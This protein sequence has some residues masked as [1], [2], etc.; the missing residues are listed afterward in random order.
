M[1]AGT[2]SARIAA[3]TAAVANRYVTSTNMKVGA[4]TLANTTPVWEG[5][6]FVTVT[7]TEVGG[8]VDTLGTIVIV[9]VDLAGNTRTESITPV[10]G[11]VATGT[12]PFRT[13]TSVTGVG[14]VIGTGNDTIT[15]GVAAGAIVCGSSGTLYSMTVNV[16]AAATI[17]IS[18]ANRTIQ[19]VP[20][21]VAVGNYI[22]GPGIDFAGHLKVA[23]TSTNDVLVVTSATNPNG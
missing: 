7:H 4:Y 15:V 12:I 14:W 3:T 20:A 21:S 13:I 1:A 19:T 11:S 18:D 17:V 9:G 6:A 2:T 16:T 23:T 8:G 5:G 10:N 22:F